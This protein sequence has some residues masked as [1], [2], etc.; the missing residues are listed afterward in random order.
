MAPLQLVLPPGAEQPT[1]PAIAVHFHELLNLWT[2][3]SFP[4]PPGIESS[5][6]AATA[7]F[8]SIGRTAVSSTDS[9]P[10]PLARTMVMSAAHQAAIRTLGPNAPPSEITDVWLT[11]LHMKDNQKHEKVLL[12]FYFSLKSSNFVQRHHS[13]QHRSISPD[14]RTPSPSHTHSDR[15]IRRQT[16]RGSGSPRRKW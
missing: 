5:S 15:Y 16:F 12:N 9:V 8:E 13:E 4:Q 2:F 7:L 14:R 10:A 6:S 11:F 3:F 1:T